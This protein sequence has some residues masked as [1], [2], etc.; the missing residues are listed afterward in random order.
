MGHTG[1]GGILS[2]HRD[3]WGLHGPP[4]DGGTHCRSHQ[5]WQGHILSSPRSLRGHLISPV[6]PLWPLSCSLQTLVSTVTPIP[7]PVG[8]P[9]SSASPDNVYHLGCLSFSYPCPKCSI[10]RG[11]RPV[12]FAEDHCPVPV[13]CLNESMW[14]TPSASSGGR[15]F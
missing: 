5:P 9:A 12:P 7:Q 6:T 11:P 1:W 15:G 8:R 4:K 10:L 2:E 3:L 14:A 13:P